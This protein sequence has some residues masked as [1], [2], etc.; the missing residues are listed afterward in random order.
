MFL[1][2]HFGPDAITPIDRPCLTQSTNGTSTGGADGAETDTLQAE[3]NTA[4]LEAAELA[5][6]HAL[7]IPVPGLE[8]AVDKA[9]AK[10]WLENLEVECSARGLADRIR[11]VIERAVETVAPLWG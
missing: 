1:E 6:L 9:V 3:K 7:G 11:A 8:I 2:S 5:R 4:R 10:V